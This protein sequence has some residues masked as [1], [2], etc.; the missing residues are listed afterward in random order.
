LFPAARRF[1]MAAAET[2]DRLAAAL[3]GLSSL[4]QLA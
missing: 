4:E 2:I 1:G 3:R